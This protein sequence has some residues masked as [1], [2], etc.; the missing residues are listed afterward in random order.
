MS[1]K[2]IKVQRALLLLKEVIIETVRENPGIN[3]SKIAE[4]LGIQSSAVNG[5]N[6]NWLIKTL[7]ECCANEL[8]QQN[9]GNNLQ[10]LANP[11]RLKS[12][13]VGIHRC[14]WVTED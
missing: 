4:T 11:P 9:T 1:E 2:T 5:G 14:W 10:T 13:R 3:S 6:R 8:N 12:E 7:L